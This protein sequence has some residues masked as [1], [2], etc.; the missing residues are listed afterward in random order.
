VTATSPPVRST[1]RVSD[2]LARDEAL[3]EV[4]VRHSA[5][6]AKLRSRALRRVMA[7]LVTVE[8]AARVAGVPVAALVRDL[9]AALGVAAEADGRQ[10][11]AHSSRSSSAQ[12][13]HPAD[14]P[15]VELDV[16]EALRAGEEPFSR[17]TA[18]VAA[19]PEGAVL[20]LRT[21]FEP[22]PL[23]AVLAKRGLLHER[24]AWADDDWSTWF[25]RGAA[26]EP[27][28]R[29]DASLP[30]LPP[31]T[32]HEQR[33][34]VRGLEPPEPMLRTLAAL[35]AL[36][37]GHTLVQVNARVPQ[38]LLPMLAE[39]GFGVVIDESRPGLV[40]VRIRREEQRSR[41]DDDHHDG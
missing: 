20:H 23:Y 26:P 37:R 36:P 31:P 21:I 18:A 41:H 1:D 29:G 28:A 34:D 32:A 6:F 5:H 27:S 16:R 15:V 25:W 24:R 9:N 38:F 30:P 13:A 7:R 2:V 40:L 22:A 14:A 3:V 10:D 35:E 33:L 12:R 17:I 39:R 8:Q 4:F 19:L 11:E